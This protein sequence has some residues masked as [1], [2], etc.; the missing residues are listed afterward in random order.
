MEKYFSN[1][2]EKPSI[3]KRKASKRQIRDAEKARE[4]LIISALREFSEK[5]FSN[6]GIEAIANGAGLNKRM[7]YHYFGSKEELYVAVLEHVYIDIR[8]AEDEIDLENLEPEEA[9]R[10]LAETTWQYFLDTPELLAIVSLENTHRGEYIKRSE[11]IRKSTVRLVSRLRSVLDRGAE[12]RIFKSSI[13][14]IQLIHSIAALG[15]YYL[16]NRFTN[17]IIYNTDLM[18]RQALETRRKY[19][20]DTILAFLRPD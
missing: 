19:I 6:A 11:K 13:D 9:I 14:E 2:S 17:S 10:Q 8:K 18:D 12:Q 7:I 20:V 15:F 4:D 5:G 3:A 1:P 16:N